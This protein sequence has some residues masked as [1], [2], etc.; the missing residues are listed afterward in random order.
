VLDIS[1]NKLKNIE[2]LFDNLPNIREL[3]I[4]FTKIKGELRGIL[5]FLDLKENFG[6]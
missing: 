1:S 3:N 4:S 5:N 6:R 2:P